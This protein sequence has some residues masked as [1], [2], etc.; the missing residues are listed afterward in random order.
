M[1][2]LRKRSVLPA[3]LLLHAAALGCGTGG[4]VNGDA[5][6][7][8]DDVAVA[9]SVPTD[10]VPLTFREIPGAQTQAS[11]HTDSSRVVIRDAAQWGRFWEAIVA[12]VSPSPPAPPIDFQRQM[13]LAAAMG[14][15]PSGGYVIS[16]DAVYLSGGTVHAVVKSVV[17][18]PTCGSASVMTAPVV[19][20]TI[21]RVDGEVRFVERTETRDCG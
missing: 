19:A 3:F 14:Q 21:D 2:R 8:G 16:I 18:G 12:N 15:R 1:T 11:S 10:S 9:P 20:V 17:P 4:T 5:K 7:R 13:V 6:K